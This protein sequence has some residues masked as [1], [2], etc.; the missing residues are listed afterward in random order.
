MRFWVEINAQGICGWLHNYVIYNINQKH[1]TK[2]ITAHK[3]KFEEFHFAD[4][5]AT[6]TMYSS[7]PYS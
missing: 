1:A 5:E 6:S 3:P 7:L 4:P 2:E